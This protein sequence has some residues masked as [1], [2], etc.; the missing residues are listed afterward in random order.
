[1]KDKEKIRKM[2]KSSRN[3]V[4][5]TKQVSDSGIYR[6]ALKTLIEED[7]VYQYG[8]GIY[9]DNSKLEDEF[10]L[11][12]CKYSRGIFSH[13]TALYLLGYSDR[14]PAKFTM[15][16]PKGYNSPSIKNENIEV[17]RVIPENYSLG[18]IEIK[19]P[20]GNT[21]KVYNLERSLCDVLRG[22]VNDIQIINPA[23]KKYANFK[24]KDINKLMKY[25]EQL[26][27]KPK[28]LNYMEVLLW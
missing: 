16:F 21:I 12:Q 15:T 25:A 10:Y 1:M 18:V 23:M 26:K 9:V 24:E 17:I 14:T 7:I 28:V 5:T 22:S 11:L 2:L 19:S 13:E 20:S 3:G 27:V 8:R 4:I 6:G